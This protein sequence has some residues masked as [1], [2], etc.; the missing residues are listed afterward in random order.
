MENKKHQQSARRKQEDATLNKL[1]VWFGIA[2]G[3]EAV[4]L[5]LKR[6]YVN[7]GVVEGEIM[8]AYGLS[9]VF[10]VLQWVAPVLTVAAVVW[11]VLWKRQGKS[12]RL[13]AICAAALFTLSFTVILTYRYYISGVEVLGVVA[14]ATAILAL[15][16]YLYQRDFFFNAL[17][18]AGGILSLWLYRRFYL[19]HP[20]RILLGFILGWVLLAAAAFLA[21][22]L[23]KS[24]GK[25]KKTQLFPEQ[26]SYL[27][28]YLTCAIT[29]LTMAA[30][31]A[32]GAALAYYAVFVLVI[33][34]FCLAVYYTVRMM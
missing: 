16:Y 19:Y 15:V 21:F 10:M 20:T 7:I 1:L 26:T 4:V 14:P 32:G 22:R 23:S 34:L 12:V 33:W 3:Y 28:T 25:W 24:S 17:F 11:A 9:R 18:T 6:F 31:M 30:A 13:P 5:F 8:F 29:A 2:I 27:P